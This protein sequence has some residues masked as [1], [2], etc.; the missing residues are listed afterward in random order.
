MANITISGT[1]GVFKSTV[2]N[3]LGKKLGYEVI[4]EPADDNPYLADYYKDTKNTSYKMQIYMLMIRSKQL[5]ELAG[6][7]FIFDRSLIEN[8]VFTEVLKEQGLIDDRDY[9]TYHW[10]FDNVMK[11]SLYFDPRLKPELAIY[12]RSSTEESVKRIIKRGRPS[13]LIVPYEY[14]DLLNKKYE[15]WYEKTSKELPMAVIDVDDKTPEEIVD[16]IIDMLPKNLKK[17][18]VSEESKK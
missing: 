12:L 17:Q 10:F 6:D 14:W 3:L 2:S 5:K 18:E 8:G 13:E 9:K 7:N 1:V 4:E 11:S 16:L 15:E